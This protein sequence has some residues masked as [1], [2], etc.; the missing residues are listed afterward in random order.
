MKTLVTAPI[1]VCVIA[2]SGVALG[3]PPVDLLSDTWVAADGLG[4]S[5]PVAPE[6]GPPRANKY[7][8]VF[9]FLWLGYAGDAGPFD[10]SK[11]LAEDPAAI[12]NPK[13][14]LWG[15]DFVPH[16]WGESV[17]GYYR[18]DDESVLRK[19]AQM[20]ADAGVD[21]IV[22]DVTNQ[23]TYPQSWQALCR[24]FDGVKRA[25]NRVPQIAFLCPFWNPAKVVRELWDDLYSRNLYS[26]LWFRWH[27]KPLILAD[28][29]PFAGVAGRQRSTAVADRD[30]QIRRFFTFRKPQPDYFRGPSRPGEWGWLEVHPQHAF[31]ETRG[32]PEEVAIGVAQNAADGKLSV[33]T[34]PR[35]HGRSFHDG[36]EPGPAGRDTSGRNFAEQWQRA[37]TIDPAFVF[38]TNWNEWIAGRFGPAN[39]PLHG[40]GAVTF[41]DEFDAEF[42]RDIE[43]MKGGHGDNYFYQMIANIRRYKGVRPIPQVTSGPIT[44]DGRFDDWA[45]VQPEYRDTIGDPVHRDHRGWGKALNYTN[46]TGRNDIVAAKVSVGDNAVAFY[47]EAR[48]ILTGSAEPNWMILFIDSDTN[49]RTGWLGYDLVVNRQRAGSST[50]T[51]ERNIGGR[52]AWGSPTEVR[53]QV[54]GTALEL[55]I[56]RAVLG[57]ANLPATIDFKWADN[58]QQTGEWSD[59]TVN[60]D[61]APNDRYNYRAIFKPSP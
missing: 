55:A 50:A 5:L 8:G 34:N 32:V 22:F 6:V 58:I 44:I 15:A 43:P 39:M 42:S 54:A 60:G 57:I 37:L 17:F 3:G 31:Y 53:F 16:H 14:P 19:H 35:S 38:V 4:R 49:P 28:P 30:E 21:T 33:F 56:P 51:V 41:V 61:A 26:D 47:V 27:D 24:V 52:Y 12:H 2:L 13:S 7:V 23:V 48:E 1:L 59:F 11:I 36:Q 20:L 10:I 25:G 40:T 45:A 9:Y 18:S 29:A 46:R